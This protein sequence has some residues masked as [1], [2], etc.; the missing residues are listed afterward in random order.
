MARE[1][2]VPVRLMRVGDLIL[3]VPPFGAQRNIHHNIA[4]TMLLKKHRPANPTFRY[5]PRGVTHNPASPRLRRFPTQSSIPARHFALKI[6]FGGRGRNISRPYNP[7]HPHA[8]PSAT[9]SFIRADKR[10]P[11]IIHKT[12]C[13]ERVKRNVSQKKTKRIFYPFFIRRYYIPIRCQG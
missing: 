12:K 1:T 13:S 10:R 4:S 7:I 9:K 3:C 6:T 5:A 2:T 8:R 11:I